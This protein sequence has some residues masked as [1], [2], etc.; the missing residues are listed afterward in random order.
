MEAADEGVLGGGVVGAGGSGALLFLGVPSP[1]GSSLT[2]TLCMY[3]EVLGHALYLLLAVGFGYE[4][5]DQV[6]GA[7]RGILGTGSA[8][9]EV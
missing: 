9:V 5:L 6:F 7:I 4:I 2:L 8:I 1:I 3:P